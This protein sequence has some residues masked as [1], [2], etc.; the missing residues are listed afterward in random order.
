MSRSKT[1]RSHPVTTHPADPSTL[2]VAVLASDA[3]GDTVGGA[4]RFYDALLQAFLARGFQTELIRVPA[5]ERSFDEILANYAYCQNLDLSAF[6]LVISTKSPTYAVRHPRH[7]S[8]LVHTVRVFDDMFHQAFPDASAMHYAQ[9]ARLHA[10][11]Q[12]ALAGVRARFAIGHEVANRLLR[13]HGLQ[14]EVIHPPLAVSGLKPGAANEYFFLPGR[15]HAWKRIDLL[16]DAIR[17]SEKP[18]RLVIAGAGEEADALKRRA[19]G[20][21]RI[22]FVGRVPNDELTALYAAALAVPFIPIHEDYGFITLEAFASGKPVITC[23]D[24][25][26]PTQFVR[27][28]VT[29]L[30]AEPNAQSLKN[31]LEWIADNREQAAQMGA[32]GAGLLAQM[33]WPA[34]VDRLVAAGFGEPKSQSGA[35]QVCVLD[36]QPISPAVGGGRLR[37]LGLYHGLGTEVQCHYLGSYDWPGESPRQIRLTDSLLEQEIPLSLD[38]HAAAH[39]LSEQAGNKTVID[40][41]FS[42]QAHLSPDWLAAAIEATRKAKVVVFSHPWVFPLVRHV[43]SPNQL[44]VYDSQNVEGYLRAQLL[45]ET[46]PV[47]AGLLREVIQDEYDLG[48]RADLIFACSQEDIERFH[49]I[50]EF[51]YDKMRVVP[52]GV[53]A[54]AHAQPTDEERARFRNALGLPGSSLVAIFVG[55]AYGPNLEAAR[56]IAA[57]L[58]AAA[59][60]VLFVIAGGVGD[61]LQEVAKTAPPNLKITGP[62]DAESLHRWL[63]AADLAVNPMFSGSGTNIKMFDFMAHCLPTVSTKIGAR[64]IDTGGADAMV[65]CAPD[66]RSIAA[67]IEDLRD[68]DLRRSIGAAARR[69]VE[70]NYAWERIS[71]LTGALLASRARLLGQSRP[72]F[73]VIIPSYE[74]HDELDALMQ[75]LQQQV[76][77]DFEVIVVDQSAQPWPNAGQSFGFPLLYRHESV[78]GAIRARNTGANLAQGRFL[79]FTDDDCLPTSDWLLAARPYFAD[80]RIAGIE[81]MITSDHLGEP[82]WRP[83]T[84]VGFEGIGFMTANLLVRAEHFVRL[85]GFDLAFDHPHFREDT[86]FGWRL[87]TLGEVPYARQVCVFH[88]AQPRSLARE[89]SAARNRFFEKDALL[90]KKHP[91]RYRELF[92]RERHYEV[93]P[94]FYEHLRAGFAQHGLSIPEWI[95]E[96]ARRSANPHS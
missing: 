78:K 51:P 69:C 91:D 46:N 95:T 11:D 40:L 1:A 70:E 33:S 9:R 28:G 53:M 20:D 76:E 71:E 79:A 21:A 90:F 52:N 67:A 30:I 3:G 29:G 41:A 84:N 77:R 62:I 63:C 45:D 73:S 18:L 88:P 10:L 4:E 44:V 82:D 27:H 36:M 66:A 19:N 86:D 56:F 57:E 75:T 54:F 61:A 43:L 48:R 6:D 12:E 25:G 55:S 35:L 42:R 80:E 39:A 81:G 16:I 15:L 26:E 94:G 34:V 74:R 22:E 96:K 60:E 58:A 2:K 68:V 37:L 7:V 14:A 47:E 24:S 5:M 50:Y 38:H 8:Y 31:A 32:A 93:T 59:P 17:L 64:G 13:W 87:Q 49:R 89:S 85:G 92:L 23:T 65:I 83:V 72:T